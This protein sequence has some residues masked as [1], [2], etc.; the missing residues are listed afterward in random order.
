[1]TLSMLLQTV[2][3]ILMLAAVVWGI[4]NEQKLAAAEKRF[5][6][7]IRRRRLKLAKPVRECNIRRNSYGREHPHCSQKNCSAASGKG[8]ILY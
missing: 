6:C 3:E 1:M 8:F 5:L 4:F 7:A 2:F